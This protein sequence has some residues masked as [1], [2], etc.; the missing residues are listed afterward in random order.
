LIVVD[1]DVVFEGS[2]GVVLV[3][4]ID[5]GDEPGRFLYRSRSV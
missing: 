1:F 2:V 5:V 3:L 4:R